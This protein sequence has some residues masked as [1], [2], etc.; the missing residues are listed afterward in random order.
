MLFLEGCYEI[1]WLIY[2]FVWKSPL[3]PGLQQEKGSWVT[4]QGFVNSATKVSSIH[5]IWRSTCRFTQASVLHNTARHIAKESYCI[6]IA[7]TGTQEVDCQ[8]SWSY[9]FC[10]KGAPD[11]LT[12][13]AFSTSR[14]NY[15]LFRRDL[16][17][18]NHVVF[19]KKIVNLFFFTPQQTLKSSSAMT[20]VVS[21]AA[22]IS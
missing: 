19:W 3:L 17:V 22:C 13:Y 5:L 11:W 2:L 8:Q 7:V 15:G 14:F 1:G 4:V 10:H 20:V 9:C 18:S 6:H 21:S 16:T 12:F